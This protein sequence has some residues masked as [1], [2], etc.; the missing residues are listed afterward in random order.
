M[1]SLRVKTRSSSVYCSDGGGGKA[2]ARL[3]RQMA[4]AAEESYCALPELCVTSTFSTSPCRLTLTRTTQT[5]F[6]RVAEVK[7]QLGRTASMT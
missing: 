6:R 7:L 1:S 4:L 2:P 3:V 5:R